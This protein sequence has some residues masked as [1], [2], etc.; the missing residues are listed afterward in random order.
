VKFH[1]INSN[2]WES[3]DFSSFSDKAKVLFLFL[4][5]NERCNFAGIYKIRLKTISHFL[6]WSAE[7]T[8]EAIKEIDGKWIVYDFEK[9]VVWIKGKLKHHKSSFS[10]E[11]QLQNILETLLEFQ[12]CCFDSEFKLTYKHF[13]L[14]D[15]P[16]QLEL[17][18]KLNSDKGI[19]SDSDG[20]SDSDSDR[21][22]SKGYGKGIEF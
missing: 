9:S 19:D 14:F 8:L 13:N 7:T 11:R 16:E 21:R 17:L 12:S 2:L 6:N 15:I 1:N 10:S 4:Y 3:E 5:T 20:V 22:V 18:N